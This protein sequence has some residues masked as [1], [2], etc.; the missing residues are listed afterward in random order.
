M[1]IEREST[2]AKSERNRPVLR[3]LASFC[4]IFPLILAQPP[5]LYDGISLTRSKIYR[6]R[7]RCKRAKVDRKVRLKPSPCRGSIITIQRPTA[8][9]ISQWFG[10][11]F[12]IAEFN[13]D[14]V[15]MTNPCLHI[16]TNAA[17]PVVSKDNDDWWPDTAACPENSKS[18]RVLRLRK[19]IGQGTEVYQRVRDAALHW[20]FVDDHHTQGM[21]QVTPRALKHRHKFV[22]DNNNNDNTG[23]GYAVVPTFNDHVYED[24]YAPVRS[25][26]VLQIWNG[27]GRRLV[28]YTTPRF[29]RFKWLPKFYAINPV[30]VVYDLVDQRGPSTMYSAT[31][32]ATVKGHWLR[33]EERVTVALRD[34]GHV[35]VEIL[36]L[37]KPA[38]SL[39]GRFVW[40]MIGGMQRKFFQQQMQ[41]F[42]RVARQQKQ[43]ENSS[44][45]RPSFGRKI[46]RRR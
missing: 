33:G 37:S 18:W 22:R 45:V 31:A 27:P 41:S 40:P 25:N 21:Q 6:W 9:R 10:A 5:D 24:V 30:S 13:H 14:A 35:D 36:S 46:L 16:A 43:D 7:E 39:A 12:S 17:L 34:S 1:I 11:R 8:E 19:R 26:Q 4:L 3:L 29:L 44:L 20:E 42:E 28:T 15:G 38:A 2:M 23:R 32:Y